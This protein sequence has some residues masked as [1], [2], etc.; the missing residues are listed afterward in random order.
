MIV[1]AGD[2][3]LL[4]EVRDR[5]IMVSTQ[6]L[7]AHWP[8]WQKAGHLGVTT[9][10]FPA[11]T[12][13]QLAQGRRLIQGHDK[14]RGCGKRGGEPRG[15]CGFYRKANSTHEG[16]RACFRAGRRS[17]PNGGLWRLGEIYRTTLANLKS[18]PYP[19]LVVNGIYDEMIPVQN[20]L[21]GCGT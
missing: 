8:F 3:D 4:V 21:E 1:V 14:Q 7:I 2:H 15:W 13:R 19:T 10:P 12:Y 17:G 20:S 11:P 5:D 16:S 9:V 6:Q 18:I